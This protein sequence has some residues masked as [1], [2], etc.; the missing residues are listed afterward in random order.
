MLDL[1]MVPERHN[2]VK[3]LLFLDVGGSMDEHVRVCEELFSAARTEF[4]H[5][6][7]F[8][9]HNCPYQD[10]WRDN[11][12][13]HAERVATWDVIHTF[14]HDYRLI[15]VGDAAM[16]PYELV[17]PG[18][19]IE[20]WNTESGQVWLGRLIEAYEKAVWLNP[21]PEWQ[22]SFHASAQLIHRI[23]GGR[24][25]PLTLEGLDAAMRAL[26]R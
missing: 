14:P 22:W 12:R 19:S 24:M 7:Y 4:K 6:E 20:D 13:R 18:G 1:Q 11:R 9:F 15:F 2:T 23:I 16:S 5:L 8:Y 25:F 10:V 21:T 3:V 17:Q 26:S